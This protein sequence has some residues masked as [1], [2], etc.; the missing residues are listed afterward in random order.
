MNFI[1]SFDNKTIL[2]PLLQRD[3]V[4]GG[5]EDVISIFID[6]LIE[7]DTD[8]NYIY[9][10][11]ENGCFVPV[12]GQQRLTTL[13]LL[14]LYLFARKHRMNNYHVEMK[15]ASRAYAQDFCERLHEH[16]ADLLSKLGAKEPLDEAITDQNW[17]IL[18]WKSNVSVKNMLRTLRVIHRKINDTNFSL[19][20]NRLV[21]APVPSITFAFLQMGKD[22]GLDDDIY[23]KMNGRGRKLSVFENLKSY[24]DEKVS[25]LPFAKEWKV[26]MDNAWADMFWTNR[27]KQQEHPEKMDDEQLFC[28]YNMLILYHMGS[29]ELSNTLTDIKENDPYL[30]ESLTAFVGKDEC[31]DKAEIQAGIIDKWQRAGMFPL[32]WFERLR[33]LSDGF[34]CFAFSKLNQLSALTDAFNTFTLYTG[35]DTSEHTTHTY[36]LCM[37]EG[38]FNRTLPLL[39]ALLAYSEGATS[40]FDWMRTMRNLILNTTINRENLP[41]VLHTIDAFS[42]QCKDINVYSFLQHGPNV[43]AML[44]VFAQSQVDEEIRKASLL[45]YYEQMTSLE[46]GRF[47]S[48]HIGALFRLLSFDGQGCCDALTPENATAYT[49]VLLELFDG[50]DNGVS[51][52]FDDGRFLL[53]RALMSF[54]PYYFGKSRNKYWSF[55]SG[56][57]EWREY[58]NDKDEHTFHAFQTLMKE[59]LV[60]AFKAG[61]RIY[62]ALS[63]R[64]ESI[65]RNYEHDLLVKDDCSYRFHFIHH[66]GIWGYMNTQHC[67]WDENNGIMLKSSR[68]NNSNRMELRTMALY[69]D[70]KYNVELKSDYKGWSIALWQRENTCLFFQLDKCVCGNRMIAI[71]VYFRNVGGEKEE[72]NNEDNYVFDL[73]VRPIHPDGENEMEKQTFADEDYN[74]NNGLFSCLIPEQMHLF[75]RK[76]NGRLHSDRHYARHELIPV[77]KNVLQGIKIATDK[78]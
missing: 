51:A 17:F 70:Y 11:E 64:V 52:I 39:Y 2:V 40:L 48:G 21:E 6:S 26:N 10:Y 20:W 22:T 38:S 54:P 75:K 18:S 25:N 45:N 69:L 67:I 49:H 8:L 35:A 43:K 29:G 24:M 37:C 4:Q 59:L 47:F 36:Q 50:G 15:F 34:F 65:S 53:R 66:P 42:A 16:L 31:T 23:V 55:N 44:K 30:Y 61:R 1:Q 32:V 74:M 73:F 12:D 3:Y 60:P 46:N 76:A 41:V 14:Y 63:E 27:N 62:D 72:R 5:R 57:N 71:D 7:K 77:L 28:L 58:L 68:G 9:G 78:E 33:L 13:W 56:M 19:I